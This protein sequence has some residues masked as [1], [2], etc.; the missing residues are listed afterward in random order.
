VGGGGGYRLSLKDCSDGSEQRAA[1][2]KW[3]V[4]LSSVFARSINLRTIFCSI[5]YMRDKWILI[6][7]N[8]CLRF[9][10]SR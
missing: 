3:L 8:T 5:A 2:K 4:L 6:L 9:F 10:S 1:K 7:L